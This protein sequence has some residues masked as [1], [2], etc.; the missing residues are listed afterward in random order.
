MDCHRNTDAETAECVYEKIVRV[1]PVEPGLYDLESELGVPIVNK[2]L[3][4][5]P[6]SMISGSN[7]ALIARRAGSGGR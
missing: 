6:V 5:T 1:K 7:L 4:V 2:R 3:S